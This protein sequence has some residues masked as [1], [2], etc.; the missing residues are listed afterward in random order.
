[1]TTYVQNLNEKLK[2]SLLARNVECKAFP[3]EN[4]KLISDFYLEKGKVDSNTVNQ[5]LEEATGLQSLDPTIVSFTPEFINHAKRLIPLTV[6]IK[7]TVF[8]IKHEGN[9]IHLVMSLPQD[10]GCMKR[11]EYVT[12]SRIKPYC[13]NS[14]AILEAV[15]TYYGTEESN[16]ERVSEDMKIL[17]ETALSS[18]N[19][20]KSSMADRMSIINDVSVIRLLQF[21]LN[22]LVYSGASDLHFECEE[23]GFRVRYR[24]DG[25]M[26]VAWTF[27][28]VV[29]E[30]VVARLKLISGMD[31]ENTG[32]PQDGSINYNLIKDKDI[33]VRVSSLPSLYGE[34]IVLRIL[35]RSKSKLTVSDLGL[36]ESESEQFSSIISRPYGMILVTGPTGSGKT[37][38]LYAVLSSL[39]NDSVNI[40]TAEDPIEY[41]L[42]GLTQVNCSAKLPFK[43][44]LRSFLRQDPDI[45][46]VG[47][48]RDGETA[49]I[50]VKAAMTGHL[51]LSTLHTNDA[52][53]AINRLA[54]MGVP[55]FLVA[56][57]QISVIA[58]RLIR[59]ICESCKAEYEPQK[60]SL[61]ALGLNKDDMRF[62]KG[63]GCEK[64][65]GTGYS[66]RLGVYE[67][68]S[69]DDN[70]GKIILE[71]KPASVLRQA[72]IDSGMITLREAAIR[73]LKNEI[74]TVEE[75]V[76]VT[77]DG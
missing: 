42:K 1:M 49:D 44:V 38:T 6:A 21:M 68:F 15:K 72:A 54:N 46:M 30:A 8:P 32:S 59:K 10:A 73:K 24:K 48:I 14:K 25:V 37:T 16:D 56:S 33:D 64:C 60:G 28:S 18:I 27:P 7:E 69:L 63:A 61:K 13:C 40:V 76:R 35:D 39:N 67:L 55:P 23:D 45:I 77:M 58:Q 9:F 70:M 19:K 53:G 22:H 51:V 36:D 29:K 43:D 62:Y 50:A 11:M 52:P 47:E 41:K 31:M 75:V 17:K 66:G 5:I 2:K 34:K 4:G 57:A 26:Q 71:N 20:L 74:T 3:T 12:G 65:S